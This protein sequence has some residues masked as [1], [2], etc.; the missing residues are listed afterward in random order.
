MISKKDTPKKC[1]FVFSVFF[2]C[3]FLP[4]YIT[5][6]NDQNLVAVCLT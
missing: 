2:F 3:L 6:V 5:D 1:H 4:P